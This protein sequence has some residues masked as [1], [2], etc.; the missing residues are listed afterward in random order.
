MTTRNIQAAVILQK[1]ICNG[2]RG[3]HQNSVDGAYVG[4]H[5]PI[6]V[7]KYYKTKEKNGQMIN[8]LAFALM[9]RQFAT[10]LCPKCRFSLAEIQ[11]NWRIVRCVQVQIL[12]FTV[13]CQIE[14]NTKHLLGR[15]ITKASKI[16]IRFHEEMAHISIVV[17]PCIA[18]ETS[19]S[20]EKFR[21]HKWRASEEPHF[22]VMWY[23]SP[24]G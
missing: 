2:S 1:A 5:T 9:W 4:T 11:Q 20:W 6:T 8:C 13:H 17:S 24:F 7:G 16:G 3:S 10:H 21:V 23:F 14:M 22:G 19:G 12:Q 18:F 15:R